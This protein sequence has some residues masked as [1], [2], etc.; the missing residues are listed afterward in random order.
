MNPSTV[1][2]A[3]NGQEWLALS[4]ALVAV[5]LG[6]F[7][8][9]FIA[10]RQ[11]RSSTISTN[12]Q[13]WIDNFGE[14]LSEYIAL[15]GKYVYLLLKSKKEGKKFDLNSTGHFK[16]RELLERMR[17]RLDPEKEAHKKFEFSL[18]NL[19]GATSF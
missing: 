11:I 13:K 4:I 8:Q 3:L 18:E 2:Q 14:E 7:I 15:C 5:I 6:P 10:N 17:L 12:R 1:E 19:H 16:R 9:L